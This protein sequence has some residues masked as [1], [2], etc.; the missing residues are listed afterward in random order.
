[1]FATVHI[2]HLTNADCIN[3]KS[4]LRARQ[5]TW[6]RKPPVSS[7]IHIKVYPLLSVH[8][9]IHSCITA[10][11]SGSNNVLKYVVSALTELSGIS[12]RR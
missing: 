4:I 2:V 11:G 1:M 6:A 5:S 10:A 12:T 8:Y 9:Q 3:C 7:Q